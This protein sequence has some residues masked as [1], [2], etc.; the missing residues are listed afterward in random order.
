[1][2]T[3]NLGHLNF[4]FYSIILRRRGLFLCCILFSPPSLCSAA[5]CSA[6]GLIM[7]LWKMAAQGNDKKWALLSILAWGPKFAN[8]FMCTTITFHIIRQRCI[9]ITSISKLTGVCSKKNL[10]Y[11]IKFD[12][13]TYIDRANQLII[14]NERK[15]NC[16]NF[17]TK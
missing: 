17:D 1:M 6:Q 4:A 15:F 13:R 8:E 5:L 2:W 11:L 16:S 7:S 10:I 14:L 12:K 3:L 9:N